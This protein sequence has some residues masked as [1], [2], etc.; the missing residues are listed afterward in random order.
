MNV[1][2]NTIPKSGSNLLNKIVE[3]LGFT[4]SNKS[5]LSPHS[6]LGNPI[7]TLIRS[8][9]LTTKKIPLSFET[10]SFVSDRFVRKMLRKGVNP[11]Y[12]N[13]HLA[14]NEEL[15]KLL[16][17]YS[18]KQLLLIRDPRDVLISYSYYVKS[19]KKH[20]FYNYFKDFN[21]DQTCELLING[22]FFNG[23]KILPFANAY[24][25]VTKWMEEKKLI[26]VLSLKFENL[27]GKKGG[28]KDEDSSE[29][30]E[31]I[32]KFLGVK[33]KIDNNKIN[34]IF[35]NSHTFRQGKINNWKYQK[36]IKID[37]FEPL[38][39]LANK[40]GY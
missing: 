22:G 17:E 28:G 2:V 32:R 19:N 16:N 3:S 5:S 1:I 27:V 37:K 7:K 21:L 25:S 10:T 18:Y 40:Y 35:G 38:M 14:Y 33:I 12:V 36:D 26:D 13:A 30:L 15:E 9:I 23:F 4:Y 11:D 20:L 39:A 31:S 34:S 29:S 6:N 8:P 24:E